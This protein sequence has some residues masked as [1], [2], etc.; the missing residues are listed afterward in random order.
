MFSSSC[1]TTFGL[2]VFR[3]GALSLTKDLVTSIYVFILNRASCKLSFLR[4]DKCQDLFLSRFALI[5]CKNPVLMM[6]HSNRCVKSSAAHLKLLNGVK[7]WT[8]GF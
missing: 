6:G 5:S 7:V 4:E 2:C 3:P 8:Q 1:A